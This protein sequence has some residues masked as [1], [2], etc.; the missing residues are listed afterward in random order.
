MIAMDPKLPE[1]PLE[2]YKVIVEHMTEGLWVGDK[3]HHT[4]YVNPTFER[5]F[6]YKKEDWVQKHSFD[7]FDEKNAEIIQI[8]NRQRK[9]GEAGHY[10]VEVLA[11]DGTPIPVLMSGAP[12]PDGGTVGIMTDLRQLKETEE[13]YHQLVET[14]NEGVWV[15][16]VKTAT[17]YANPAFLQMLGCRLSDIIGKKVSTFFANTEEMLK[18]RAASKKGEKG[19]HYEAILLGCNDQ[20]IPVLVHSVPF[21]KGSLMTVTD[22]RS[23][24]RLERSER[25]FQTFTQYSADAMVSL[26]EGG[27][28]RAWNVGAERMFGWT[29]EEIIGKSDTV[30]IP[31]EK[32]ETGETEY[33][34][35]EANL[36]GFVRNH[37]TTRLHKNGS[38]IYVSLTYT[39]LRDKNH[40][41]LGYSAV[42]RDITLQKRW[43]K[44]LQQRF[45]KMQEAY[46]EMGKLRRHLD[47][48]I[49]LLDLGIISSPPA[50]IARF[51][52]HAMLMFTRADAVILRLFDPQKHSLV[53]AATAGS[54]TE[55]QTKGAIPLKNSLGEQVFIT[56][57]PFKILDVTQEP[58]YLTPGFARK[59]NLRSLLLI[60]LMVR[61]EKIGTISVYISADKSLDV[62][63]HEFIPHFA[64]QAALV[65]KLAETFQH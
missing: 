42:Y 13:R 18:P 52:V 26:N 64:K 31:Q 29:V 38:P 3:D 16:D 63:D 24:K 53:L 40:R 41:C 17:L 30:L 25:E 55:W 54:A 47:Y 33:L 65:L 34:F 15:G 62:L 2:F 21:I 19:A 51:I 6:G 50:D 36:K 1:L 43:E 4:R 35:N 57:K 48:F 37:E 61:D 39:A 46:V 32:L 22:L 27:V 10:E 11:K 28:I 12:T 44:D 56:Q 60:P 5:L 14:M 49:E 45:D 23:I 8:A 7:Y 59:N 58:L 20:P 9:K